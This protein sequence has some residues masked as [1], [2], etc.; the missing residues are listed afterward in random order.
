M[1][2]SLGVSGGSFFLDGR[3]RLRVELQLFPAETTG[4]YLAQPLQSDEANGQQPQLQPQPQQHNVRIV[5]SRRAP[6]SCDSADYAYAGS[7]V[8][9]EVYANGV[10]LEMP[11][12]TSLFACPAP[13]TAGATA[14]SR[15]LW[16]RVEIDLA[17][18][19]NGEAW[20]LANAG[21]VRDLAIPS[22][23]CPFNSIKGA[24]NAPA[25]QALEAAAR[26][27]AAKAEAEA[28]AAA[29]AAQAQAEAEA[30]A[31]A[32]AEATAQAQAEAEAA[33]KAKADAE[34]AAKA[35]IDAKAAAASAAVAPSSVNITAGAVPAP[36]ART[37]II[38]PSAAVPAHATDA[39]NQAQQAGWPGLCTGMGMDKGVAGVPTAAA[40]AA[41][42]SSSTVSW[43]LPGSSLMGDAAAGAAAGDL[44]SSSYAAEAAPSSPCSSARAS[45]VLVKAWVRPFPALQGQQWKLVER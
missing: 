36:E 25:C 10:T 45:S 21:D 16:L 44:G 11:L 26:E 19:P 14:P 6:T 18:Q 33:A 43:P 28:E 12:P 37:T 32:T 20:Y 4:L 38:A 40:A 35:Q 13:I 23:R 30:A 17:E 29:A 8:G 1:I 22:K 41:W 2:G 3:A 42:G 27:A 39:G 34:A 24:C 31:K 15:T 5:L 9:G 7:L